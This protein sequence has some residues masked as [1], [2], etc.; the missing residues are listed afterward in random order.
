M[1]CQVVG[2]DD[3]PGAGMIDSPLT[4]VRTYKYEIGER[5][6]ESVLARIAQPGRHQETIYLK[7][8]VVFR[9]SAR[10]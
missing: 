2:F 8:D 1:D 3:I 6:A 7:T 10:G 4:T 9:G 5:A